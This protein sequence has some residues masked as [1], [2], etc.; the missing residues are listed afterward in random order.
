MDT[1]SL[2]GAFLQANLILIHEEEENNE[3][4]MN[5]TNKCFKFLF[6]KLNILITLNTQHASKVS[7]CHDVITLQQRN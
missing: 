1:D 6:L 4:R 3:Q 5:K 2:A 7:K